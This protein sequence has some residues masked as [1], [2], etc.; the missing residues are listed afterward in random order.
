MPLP[1][2][3]LVAAANVEM[4]NVTAS[5]LRGAGY[6]VRIARNAYEALLVLEQTGVDLLVTGLQMSDMERLEFIKRAKA[7]Y[8][9]VRILQIPAF[10]GA[11]SQSQATHLD[12]ADLV[13][14]AR[15]ELGGA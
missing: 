4:G 13:T 1:P 11:A 15:R 7:I 9:E 2:T 6:R 8:P 14:A 12:D 3:V 10:S 5:A